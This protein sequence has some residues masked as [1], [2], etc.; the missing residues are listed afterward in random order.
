MADIVLSILVITNTVMGTQKNGSSCRC[1]IPQ[2][3]YFS[4]LL[5]GS[6]NFLDK[7]YLDFSCTQFWNF[8][9]TS[10]SNS[11]V[12]TENSALL[13]ECRIY[14]R[15]NVFSI[16]EREAEFRNTGNGHK[17]R[18]PKKH[19]SIQYD[20]KFVGKISGGTG[21]KYGTK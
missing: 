20:R 5:S 11:K 6:S 18:R 9:G 19:L 7:S 3:K 1:H 14:V 10:V 17:L 8:H 4:E 16:P 2:R 21:S 12:W 15:P 13:L